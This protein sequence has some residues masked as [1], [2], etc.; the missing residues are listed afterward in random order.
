VHVYHEYGHGLTWRMIGGMS[1]LMSGSIGE[2]MSD[3]LALYFNGDDR[4]AEYSTGTSIGIRS[5]P[6]TNYPRTYGDFSGS[7]VH[8]NGEIYAATMWKLRELWLAK[9]GSGAIEDLLTHVVDGMNYTPS[10]PAFE[11]MR[12]GIL[13]SIT[14]EPG[15][16]ADAKREARCVVWDAFSQFGVGVGADGQASCNIFRCTISIAETFA[17]PSEC[18]GTPANTAPTVNITAPVL[19]GQT[20]NVTQGSSVT[21]T[22]SAT[23]A[24]DGNLTGG[25]VWTSS[26]HAQPIGTGG[27]FATSSLSLGT[28]TI[29]AT[30]TDGGNLSGSST[31]TVTV[32]PPSS[33]ITL[34]ARAYKTKGSRF[35]DLTWSGA[36]SNVDVKRNGTVVAT[37]TANDGFYTDAVGGKGGGSFT[38]QVCNTGTTTCSNS[39]TVTF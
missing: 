8:F 26:L 16:S 12:D 2:G 4:L 32:N 34:S 15:P 14:N 10:G 20:A 9:Y 35:V 23:D 28:H 13:S 29:T 21:F 18:T 38:Y 5:A 25:L 39:V 19:T 33:G 37:G 22:G 17:K 7:S 1:G 6:Y 36:T 11:D 3:T 27:S 24:E 31:I 30:A